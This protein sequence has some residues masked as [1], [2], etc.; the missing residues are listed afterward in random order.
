MLVSV[1]GLWLLLTIV[2]TFIDSSFVGNRYL[3]KVVRREFE[4]RTSLLV[5]LNDPEALFVEYVPKMNWGKLM[6]DNASDVGLLAVDQQKREIRFEGDKERWRIPASAI[7]YCQL[8]VFVQQQGHARTKIYYAVLRANHR[9]G[10]WEVPIRPRGKTG[11]FSGKRKK[12]T[13]Q[14]VEAIQKIQG[15]KQ[16]VLAGV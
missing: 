9:G 5:D 14:L 16:D 11:P 7:T 10:F 13:Q 12:A 1:G 3:R 2:V 4:R 8:E 6:L 15:E